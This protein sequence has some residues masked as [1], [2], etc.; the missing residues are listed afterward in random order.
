[1]MTIRWAAGLGVNTLRVPVRSALAVC[2]SGCIE[3]LTAPLCAMEAPPHYLPAG[4]HQ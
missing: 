1:M 4:V 2:L 3:A